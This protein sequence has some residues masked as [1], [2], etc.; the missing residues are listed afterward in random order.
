MELGVEG[1]DAENTKT[2]GVVALC[3]IVESRE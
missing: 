3:H 1:S 2:C